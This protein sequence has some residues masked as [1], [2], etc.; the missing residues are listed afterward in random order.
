MA[1]LQFPGV[2]GNGLPMSIDIGTL[3]LLASPTAGVIGFDDPITQWAQREIRRGVQKGVIL[4]A[5]LALD[6]AMRALHALRDDLDAKLDYIASLPAGLRE[7]VAYEA[8]AAAFNHY[9][10][11]KFL[12]SYVW[13]GGAKVTL[14]LQEMIDCNPLI[15]LQRSK[16]FNSLL[17]SAVAQPGAALPLAVSILAGAM[18][19]GTLGQFTV[20]M[21]GS[22]TAG[23]DGTWKASGKMSFYDEWDFDP[24]DFSKGGRSF[25]GEVKTR[26]GYVLLPGKGFKIDSVETD[27]SQTQADASVVWAGGTPKLEPDRIAALDVELRE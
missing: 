11:K 24:K 6:H 18:T 20:R 9:L 23:S 4:V 26:V 21:A 10:P 3:G 27:F 22:L 5:D 1:N 12:R 16:A 25:Q 2:L 14:T 13:G 15:R 7:H 19:N 8:F 17:A